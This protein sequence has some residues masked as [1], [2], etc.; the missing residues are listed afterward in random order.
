MIVGYLIYKGMYLEDAI[1]LIASKKPWILQ[2]QGFMKQFIKYLFIKN[3]INKC[4][5]VSVCLF[6]AFFWGVL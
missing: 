3:K 4:M 6:C 2:N 1:E 5:A